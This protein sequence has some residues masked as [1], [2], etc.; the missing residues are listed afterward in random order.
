M[1]IINKK[2]VFVDAIESCWYDQESREL[3]I[4]TVGGKEHR[5][6]STE[7]LAERQIQAIITKRSV[8]QL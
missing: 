2:V 7:K 3:V 1:I 8:D 4:D 6:F 5:L